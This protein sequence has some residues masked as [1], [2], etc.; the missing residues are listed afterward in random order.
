MAAIFAWLRTA[1]FSRLWSPL[2]AVAESSYRPKQ[3][4][5]RSTGAPHTAPVSW[6]PVTTLKT[7]TQMSEDIDHQQHGAEVPAHLPPAAK[8][9]SHPTFADVTTFWTDPIRASQ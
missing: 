3:S 8:T 1:P 9:Q 7:V 5:D 4:H 2:A 6:V